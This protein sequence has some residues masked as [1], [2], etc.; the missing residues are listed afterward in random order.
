[1]EG[2]QVVKNFK[3]G[4]KF[5]QGKPRIDLFPPEA[6]LGISE[7]LTY[8]AQKYA[9]RNWEKGMSWGRVFAAAMRHAWKWWWGEKLDP[10]SGLPHLWHF[11]CGVVFL[12]TYEARGVGTDDRHK[13]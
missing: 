2:Q 4:V 1:M 8:G 11:G 13:V 10:E 9:D 7:V 5:D 12:I 3:E 6:L